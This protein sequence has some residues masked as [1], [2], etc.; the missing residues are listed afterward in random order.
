MPYD[1]R[2]FK[3]MYRLCKTDTGTCF[4]NNPMTLEKVKKQRVALYLSEFRKNGSMMY[5]HNPDLYYR[6]KEQAHKI[7]PIHSIGRNSEIHDQYHEILSG[8]SKDD[9]FIKQL[10]EVGLTSTEYL[11]EAKLRARE[12]GYDPSLLTFANDGVHKLQYETPKGIKRF[13][14]VGF[15]DHII[16]SHLE[17]EGEVDR[18]YAAMKRHVFIQSHSKISKIHHLDR[19][20]S[21]ELSIKIL[22]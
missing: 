6:L 14:R 15:R 10:A 16:W 9:E 19:Y 13:G 3:G 7:D 1:I 12:N 4:S 18:G 17:R 20:S 2:P 21:N 11:Q 22:W 5:R 8:G